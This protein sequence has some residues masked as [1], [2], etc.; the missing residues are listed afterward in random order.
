MCHLKTNKLHFFPI[1]IA[2]LALSIT[3]DVL[4]S[5][6][7]IAVAVKSKG[8]VQCQ[9]N[10]SG[11]WNPVAMGETFASGD[12]I[13]T[14]D[15]GLVMLKFMLDGSMVRLKPLSLMTIAGREKSG[16]K[17][18]SGNAITVSMGAILFNIEKQSRSG[19][20]LIR[21][22]TSVATIKGTRFWVIV[23]SDSSTVLACLDGEVQMMSLAT[24]E[25]RAIRA[26][27]TGLCSRESF[28][29]RKTL[30]S[31]LPE[32]ERI[33]NLEFRFKDKENRK[34]SLKIGFD[35]LE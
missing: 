2:A 10:T 20:L 7:A 9:K 5:D 18:A 30:L 26:G 3:T 23:S 27:N 22:P 13:K 33:Q 14:A 19:D 16:G 29:V 24:E 1:M 21:T 11:S 32:D 17:D 12:R 25:K 35:E 6:Q 34:R 28:T 4:A 8:N 31:D 15:D